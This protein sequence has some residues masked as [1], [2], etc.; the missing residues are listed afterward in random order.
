M[1]SSS[2]SP[3]LPSNQTYPNPSFQRSSGNVGP[4]DLDRSALKTHWR[5]EGERFPSLAVT[6]D[7]IYLYLQSMIQILQTTCDVDLWTLDSCALWWIN[8]S[9]SHRTF[10]KIVGRN[11]I[12]LFKLYMSHSIQ[13]RKKCLIGRIQS[14]KVVTVVLQCSNWFICNIFRYL[15]Q[16]G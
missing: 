13:H 8:S 6:L 2:R 14:E 7:I 10:V 3:K 9:F 5:T 4:S 11:F 12:V 1:S 15:S 16:S